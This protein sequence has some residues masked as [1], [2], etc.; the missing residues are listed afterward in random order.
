L[1]ELYP[2]RAIAL[3]AAVYFPRQ[4]KFSVPLGAFFI[5]DAIINYCYGVTL[6]DPQILIRYFALILVGCF[7]LLFQ[8][9]GSLKKLLPASIAGSLIFRR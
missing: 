6:L 2:A 1:V 4:Y 5:S 8:N 7:G 3:C 9:R